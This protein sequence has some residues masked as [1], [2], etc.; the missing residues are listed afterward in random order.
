MTLLVGC[1]TTANMYPTA[2][3]IKESRAGSVLIAHVDNI[4]S[5]TG[6]FKVVY[7]NGDICEG[8]WSSVA[9]QMSAISWGHIFNEYGNAAGVSTVHA[10]MPGINRG[11]A[12]A[13]CRSGNQLQVEFYTGSGTANG[14][15]VAKDENGNVFKL[16]F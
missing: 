16:I 1:S 14:T 9:P 6:A 5:N 10:N 2:G 7:P 3:P 8:R 13:V 4:M 11:E 15:G 12:M